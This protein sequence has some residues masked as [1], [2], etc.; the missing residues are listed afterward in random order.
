MATLKNTTINDTG[1]LQLPSGNTS[2]RPTAANGMIRYNSET[3][4][5]EVYANSAWRSFSTNLAGTVSNPATS[6]TQIKNEQGS[7]TNGTYYYTLSSGTVQL[8]TDF[9]S[10]SNYPMVLVT[11][12]SPND[13]NQYLTTANNIGDLATIAT[14]TTPSRSSKIS[15][16]DMNY[17]IAPN[18]IRWAIVGP[19]MTF[20]RLDDNPNWYS[21]LGAS[22]SCSYDRGFYDAYATPSNTPSWFTRAGGY[23][24]GYEGC[25]GVYTEQ[26]Q[27]M[28][29]T[30][31]H[32]GDGQHFGGYSGGSARRGATPSPYQTTGSNDSW[33]QGGYVFLN[34]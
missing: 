26:S 1:F 29:L 4:K 2:Q 5:I 6:A 32:V 31:I 25:G 7:P 18:T 20:Y 9:T 17:I 28:S 33:S 10:F 19:G 12:I 8:Y 21:N 23:F 13:Q 16:A 24:G 11:K 27:W 15:D 14:N 30:G 34:W 3:S 22:A